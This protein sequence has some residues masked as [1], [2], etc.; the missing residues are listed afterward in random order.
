MVEQSS[1]L[2]DESDSKVFRGVEDGS[3]VL[4]ACRGCNVFDAASSSS[5]DVVNEWELCVKDYR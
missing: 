4:G 3:V 5:V 1:T 2:L